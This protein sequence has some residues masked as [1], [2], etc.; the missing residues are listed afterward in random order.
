MSEQVCA[1]VEDGGAVTKQ[2]FSRHFASTTTLVALKFLQMP[3]RGNCGPT[4][5]VAYCVITLYSNA[6]LVG[7]G[8]S[9]AKDGV[10]WQAVH[11]FWTFVGS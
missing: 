7:T 3:P 4:Q 11:R 2:T 8:A 9:A 6:Q 1:W 5:R 10:S